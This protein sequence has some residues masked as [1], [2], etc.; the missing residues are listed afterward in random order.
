ML[1]KF[2]SLQRQALLTCLQNFRRQPVISLITSLMIG[3]I[4]TWPTFLW[5][6]SNQAKDAIHQ[7]QEKAYFSFYLPSN[8]DVQQREDVLL[9]LRSM[10][11][12]KTIEVIEPKAVLTNLL[13]NRDRKQIEALGLQNPLPYVIEITPKIKF[14][15]AVAINSFY[16]SIASLP[17]IHGSKNDFNWFHRLGALEQFLSHFSLLLL[18][19]LMLGVA[20]L[21]SNTL[22]MV[23][24]ARYEEIQILKLIGASL[25]FILGPFLYAGAIYGLIGGVVAILAV[26]IVLSLLQDNFKSLA[27]LYNHLGALPLMSFSDIILVFSIAM[28]L[29][30]LSAW[31]FVRYY[32]SAIE[33][34]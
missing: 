26:D 25:R 23:I 9:R 10:T 19:I 34:V 5:V 7:W 18:G 17:Y 13:K 21:V 6:L 32:L 33:P 20:F 31:I 8:I 1:N 11:D 16:Q 15:D 4:L 2:F 3:F 22:R 29:G 12:I 30:W 27:M 28:G 24:H 14:T